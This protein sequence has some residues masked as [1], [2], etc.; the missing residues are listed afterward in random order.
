MNKYIYVCQDNYSKQ[1]YMIVLDEDIFENKST[2]AII[3]E[4][5]HLV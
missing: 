4:A 5:D 3:I 2:R 1:I